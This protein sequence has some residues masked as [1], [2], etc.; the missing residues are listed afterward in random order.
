[1]KLAP[2]IR[3]NV[4]I[5]IAGKQWSLICLDGALLDGFVL[6]SRIPVTSRRRHVWG[7]RP[8]SATVPESTGRALVTQGMRVFDADLEGRKLTAGHSRAGV[9]R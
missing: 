7:K 6:D 1:M 2:H 8:W 3:R 4:V 5:R 9:R